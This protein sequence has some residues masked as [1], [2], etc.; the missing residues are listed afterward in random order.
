MKKVFILLL[1]LSL[2][3]PCFAGVL[4]TE[5]KVKL[6]DYKDEILAVYPNNEGVCVGTVTH[7]MCDTGW[8]AKYTDAQWIDEVV[9]MW[10]LR[11]IKLGE[12]KIHS[13]TKVEKTIILE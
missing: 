3:P 2:S 10:L 7:M 4:T 12:D 5:A 6:A 13:E 9:K 1:M 8:V 11:V